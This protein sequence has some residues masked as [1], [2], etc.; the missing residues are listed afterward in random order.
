MPTPGR[1]AGRSQIDRQDD[2]ERR[3]RRRAWPM[4][5]LAGVAFVIGAIAGASHSPSYAH[6][7]AERFT[8]AWASNNYASMY[9]DIDPS[10]RRAVTPNQ[11]ANV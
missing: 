9:A 11:F 10:A 6:T 2:A 1:S 5:A 4:V 8:A 7:L 3:R